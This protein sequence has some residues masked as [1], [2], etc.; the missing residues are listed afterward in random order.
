MITAK[1]SQKELISNTPEMPNFVV[2]DWMRTGL[3]LSGVNIMIFAYIYSQ[4]FDNTHTVTT[5]LATMSEWFG[6]TRQTLTRNIERMPC[7]IK[8]TSDEHTYGF[9]LFNYYKVDMEELLKYLKKSKNKSAYENF[10]LSYSQILKLK[11]PEDEKDIDDYFS[12][13]I[14]WH[15]G[16]DDTLI[17]KVKSIV[18]LGDD[19]RN[20]PQDYREANFSDS[21]ADTEELIRS[22][23]AILS[24]T[25]G[26]EI[27]IAPLVD[28]AK[29]TPTTASSEV[30]AKNT[31][32]E[33]DDEPIAQKPLTVEK[34]KPK[35]K[36]AKSMADMGM[37][38]KKQR[39]TKTSEEEKAELSRKHF[40]DLVLTTNQYVALK[41]DNNEELKE[42]LIEYIKYRFEDG[43]Y[44]TKAQWS[45]LLRTLNTYRD[46]DTRIIVVE[47]AI[48]G[49]YKKFSYESTE[50]ITEMK[51]RN[52]VADDIHK[53]I[54]D[55]CMNKCE[56]NKELAEL[57]HEYYR[58]V[59][60]SIANTKQVEEML[61]ML[62]STYPTLEGK[63]LSVR[64]AFAGGWKTLV[65]NNLFGGG[66][67]NSNNN[68][69]APNA[70]IIIGENEMEEKDKI[71]DKFFREKYLYMHPDIKTKLTG[72]V[73]ETEV[74]KSMSA[75][76][77]EKN[78]EFL[79][80]HK[81][82]P[83]TMLE[84]INET[85]IKNRNV[86]CYENFEETK[87]VQKSHITLEER[88]NNLIRSRRQ[89]CEFTR[90]YN[91]HDKRFEGM[92]DDFDSRMYNLPRGNDSISYFANEM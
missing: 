72:Y 12:G 92:P 83:K 15:Y 74:G 23:C 80:L 87:K 62:D 8:N 17:E 54:D 32:T 55:F 35:R 64:K 7:I 34:T 27:T 26:R 71:I 9:Y 4:S 25:T 58:T 59:N 53:I 65:A 88:S 13:I 2:W 31:T 42:V 18:R 44:P 33:T 20:N 81:P 45:A 70:P 68:N 43:S 77:F 76:T 30:V 85:I 86:F 51:R 84:A 50:Q 78:L 6:I 16:I 49:G 48:A 41:F 28:N 3:G 52:K 61:N 19:V 24:N 1:L 73:H 37:V 66:Y 47:N 21:I 14:D 60:T 38:S 46:N 79:A 39:R 89:E 82:D 29:T 56:N 91:P 75:D 22:F 69:S 11:F 57:I 40:D 5:S 90:H 36:G 67:S 10:M 63:L